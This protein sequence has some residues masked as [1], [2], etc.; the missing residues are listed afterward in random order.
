MIN[1]EEFVPGQRWVSDTEPEL[2]LGTVL[3]TTRNAVAMLFIAAEERRTYAKNNAPLTRVRFTPGDSVENSDGETL[4]ITAVEEQ[5]G[6]LAYWGLDEE[7][8]ERRWEEIDLNAFIQFNKPQERL[9]N[10]QI[11]PENLFSLRYATLLHL[12]RVEQSPVRG[13]CG[14]RTSLIPHQLYIAHE[15]ATRHAP[16]VLLADEVG[17]GKT[18][19]AGLILHRQLLTGRAER[20]LIVAP[21]PLLHQWLVE[22]LR[23]F[24]LHFSL[25]DEARCEEAE[26]AEDN[27]F[28][29]DPLVLC[30]L[31]FLTRSPVR[32]QQALDAG[33]DTLVVDEAHHLQWDE[34]QPSA[35]YQC[36]A[37]LAEATP[38]VLLLTATPEQLGKASHFARLR[39]LD[40]GRFHSYAQFLDEEKHYESLAHL[41]DP[42]TGSAPLSGSIIAELRAVAAQDK[43]ETLLEQVNDAEHGSNARRELLRLL[44]DRHGTGRVLFRNTRATVKG[45]PERHA[46]AHVLPCP[47]DYQNPAVHRDPEARL[48]PES[49]HPTLAGNDW[50]R[51]DPRVEK[52][53]AI[54][55]EIRPEK[56]LV[57]CAKAAT[58]TALEEALRVK[59]GVRTAVFH[60]GMSIVARDRAA[61]WF[62]DEEDGAQVLVC[63]EIGSEGRNFQFAHHLVLFDLPENPDLLEQR[64]GRLDRIGQRHAIRIHALV[65][66][67]TAQSVLY[68]WYMEGLNAVEHPCPA[69]QTVWQTLK[70]KLDVLLESPNAEGEASL[71]REAQ[72]LTTEI[73]R[74]LHDGRDHLLELNSCRPEEAHRL[75]EAIAGLEQSGALWEYL[76]Q[77][78][79]G[80]GVNVEE[81]SENCFILMPGDNMLI[82]HFPELP[83]DG[84][85]VTVSR[86]TALAREDMQFLTW[87]HPMVRGVNDLI[88]GG[89]HGNAAM[90]LLRQPALSSGELLL[91]AIFLLECAAPKHLQ[92]GRFLPP[93]LIR[94]LIDAQLMDVSAKLP[95]ESFRPTGQVIDRTHAV[96]L[97]RIQRK[98]L[99]KMLQ[100]AEKH[101]QKQAPPLVND[102][103]QKM[104][105]TLSAELKRLAALKKI[106]PS[107][108]T[109]EVEHLRQTVIDT[110]GYLQSAQ[111]RLDAV[112]VILTA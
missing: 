25:L 6:L 17:L 54:L 75:V 83:A 64:I 22:M 21:E 89:G 44:L 36:I 19:E 24:N 58:A 18:I 87:E 80:Y 23:R 34:K 65:L 46:V 86:A 78:Y 40:P 30:G 5:E 93:T 38:S 81:H 84:V 66:E 74:E 76:E 106:N 77:V 90:S 95:F 15:V 3:E 12:G 105:E 8:A 109:E 33:W 55:A 20:V 92:V 43:A 96:E 110:H 31:D 62:A 9:F 14:G 37:A 104:L 98:T 71:V 107:V 42:L 26:F 7:G 11:D 2:G 1:H 68:R 13:L 41:I 57:I 49:A 85:T 69:A 51:S 99:V 27:L 103:S 29:E 112:R 100:A 35:E 102:A 79:D 67:N 45:F 72:E 48:H 59:A 39:L 28:G 16:R 94:V 88:L 108:R 91:E 32:Q 63:S 73:L 52:L 97:A 70:P 101:A 4:K 56:A 50:W 60:E 82:A 53:I 10:G 61:A 111:L 47:A